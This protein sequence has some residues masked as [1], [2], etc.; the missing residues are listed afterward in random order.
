MI[1]AVSISASATIALPHGETHF[2]AHIRRTM[3]IGAFDRANEFSRGLVKTLLLFLVVRWL[4][5]F[6]EPLA[7]CE[8]ENSG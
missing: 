4:V 5:R 3:R 7:C 2:L 6:A 8:V 1:A